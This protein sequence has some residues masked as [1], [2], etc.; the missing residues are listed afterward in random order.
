MSLRALLGTVSDP[1]IIHAFDTIG[2]ALQV[3]LVVTE[4]LLKQTQSHLT[5]QDHH[6]QLTGVASMIHWQYDAN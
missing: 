3:S 5:I 6:A 1:C 4:G 2:A